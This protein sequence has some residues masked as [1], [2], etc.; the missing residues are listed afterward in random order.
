MMYTF[1]VDFGF[2]GVSYDLDRYLGYI[3][4]A[5]NLKI[6]KD[7]ISTKDEK[8]VI[9]SLQEVYYIISKRSV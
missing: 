4:F 9:L 8:N 3:M 7:K 6:D 2:G 1:Y 5:L